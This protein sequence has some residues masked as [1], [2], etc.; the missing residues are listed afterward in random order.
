MLFVDFISSSRCIWSYHKVD[1][2]Q[3]GPTTRVGSYHKVNVFGHTIKEVGVQHLVTYLL[4]YNMY[5]RP[6]LGGMGHTMQ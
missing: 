4:N 6:R 1:S 2:D 3:H 5:I